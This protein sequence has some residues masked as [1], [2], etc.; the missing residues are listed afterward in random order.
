MNQI[1]VLL[2]VLCI[3]STPVFAWSNLSVPSYFTLDWTNAGSGVAVGSVFTVDIAIDGAGAFRVASSSLDTAGITFTATGSTILPEL[4]NQQFQMT[5]GS[6]NGQAYWIHGPEGS[7]RIGMKG[8]ANNYRFDDPSQVARITANLSG[9]DTNLVFYLSLFESRNSVSDFIIGMR[10]SS[11]T[12]LQGGTNVTDLSSVA[13]VLA[14]GQSDY[15]DFRAASGSAGGWGSLE[16]AFRSANIPT[17]D[18]IVL[19]SI[20]SSGCVLQ[21]DRAVPLWGTATPGE[22]VVVQ[23]ESQT[24]QAVAD[25]IG[26]WRVELAPVPPGGPFSITVSSA[27]RAPVV[28]TDVYFGDVWLL[29]GQS[30]MELNLGSQI[31]KFG[32]YYPPAPTAADDF[33]DV[34]F[35]IIQAVED[36]VPSDEVT[37]NKKWTRWKASELNNMSTLGYF[38]TRALNEALDANGMDHVPLG[39]IKVCKGATAAEQWI[40]AEALAAMPEPLIE[41]ATKN[42]TGY[43]N[44]MI[45]PIQDFAF[46]GVLWYQGEGNSRTHKRQLQYPLVM[47]TLIESW[48]AQWGFDFP[49]YYVQLAPYMNFTPVPVDVDGI[50]RGYE[51]WA[52][53]REAQ[54]DTLAVNNSRM[55]C[56]IDIGFQGDI[57]PPF[58]D[59]VGQR[60]ANIALADTYGLNVVS[61][62]PTVSDVTISGSSVIITFDNV[63]D[64]LRTQ[65]V[66][67][68]PDTDEISLGYLPVSV[69]SN[70]LAGFALCGI[71]KKF[72]W[73]SEAEII[74]TN[75]VRIS[76]VVDVPEPV[77]V[78]Y[79]W[80]SFP[81]CNLFNSEG[82]PAEPFRTDSYDYGT[83]SGAELT[84]PKLNIFR[85]GANLIL[86]WLPMTSDWFLEHSYD[87]TNTSWSEIS[88][89]RG[90]TSL[91]VELEPWTSVFFRLKNLASNLQ[92]QP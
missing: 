73:A 66:D 58:K 12:E 35:A 6:V 25:S 75:Q 83:S 42:P 74:S 38:F 88:G 17:G 89:S 69:S 13:P 53:T 76:N 85:N 64:G 4:F 40:S 41:D 60:L 70:V 90:K 20:F 84:G 27:G 79:A 72:F 61:R 68:Q 80:Q 50:G 78:R 3:C 57:H 15:F 48:R 29:A 71:D 59:I 7:Y 44:G 16:F 8:G 1:K 9:L 31:R 36:T 82:L 43:Y 33:D 65:A 11:G 54:T 67:A 46:K 26:K 14:G 18:P 52:W 10:D 77:A 5:F 91:Q 51:N 32:D 24:V 55:A 87:L 86:E 47:Q 23:L 30:N 34:R 2:S 62:G 45:A 28:V 37:M 21:R 92:G 22:A 63:A 56:I 81:R 19:A 49:F 39:L